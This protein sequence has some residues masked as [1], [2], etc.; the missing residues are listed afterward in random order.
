[1]S[2]EEGRRVLERL[3]EHLRAQRL[4]G[5]RAQIGWTR[6]AA[7]AIDS[8][9]HG[10]RPSL[11]TA[12]GLRRERG[13]P[14]ATRHGA[15]AI[16]AYKLHSAGQSWEKIVEENGGRWGITDKRTLR[17]I[18]ANNGDAIGAHLA[19]NIAAGDILSGQ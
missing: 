6:R 13:R 7:D 4:P 19:E 8:Y 12:F 5:R 15:I 16:E 10:K 1:M 2:A 11:D 9:L 17:R 14:K 3:L 18:V